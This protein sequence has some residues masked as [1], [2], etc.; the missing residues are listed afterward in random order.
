MALFTAL[1]SAAVSAAV[2]FATGASVFGLATGLSAI[3]MGIGS[4]AMSAVTSLLQPKRPNIT[5]FNVSQGRTL[6]I[7]QPLTYRR[8]LYG[9]SRISGSIG[10]FESTGDNRFFHMII[11]HGE[12]CFEEIGT[13]YF[14][15]EPIFKD[16]LDG[17]GFVTSG[18]FF[19]AD[20]PVRIK[21]HLGCGG[22]P[23]NQTPVAQAAG[24]LIGTMSNNGGLAASFDGDIDQT[25][26]AS[27]EDRFVLI[28]YI[29]KDWG[30]AV[31]KTITGFQAWG[32][33]TTGFSN[34]DGPN[35]PVGITITLQGSTD[36][37]GASIVDLGSAGPIDNEASLLITKMSGITSTTAYRY[38]RLK[39]EHPTSGGTVE[40]VRCT[41][42]IFYIGPAASTDTAD[43]DLVSEMTSWTTDHTLSGIAYTYIRLDANQDMY[44]GGL[45]N[46][47]M[48]CK[49]ALVLDPRDSGTR[50]SPNPAL[51]LYDYLRDTKVGKSVPVAKIDTASVN[52][53]ADICDEFVAV[54]DSTHVVDNTD[55]AND[56]FTL[57][58]AELLLKY[59]TGDHVE[60]TT[61]GALPAPFVDLTDYFV[62]VWQEQTPIKVKLA[63]TYLNALAGTAIDITT[64]GTGIHTL[65]KKAE[66]RYTVNGLVDADRDPSLVITELL[67]AMGGR[68]VKVGSVWK[69]YAAGYV[70][71]TITIDE[72]NLRGPLTIATK[73]SRRVRFNAVKGTYITPLNYG[74]ISNYP[75][76]TNALY[77]TEDNEKRIYTDL[78]LPYTSRPGQ[79][80]RLAK[81]HLERHRQQITVLA[82][83]NLSGFEIE[84]IDIIK[85]NYDRASWTDKEFDVVG[86]SLTPYTAAGGVPA[87]GIDLELRETAE[88]VYDWNS[89]EETIVDPAPDTNMPDAFNVATPTGL[90]LTSGA[91]TLFIKADGTVVSRILASWTAAGDF[92]VNEYEIQIKKS[93]DPD[94]AASWSHFSVREGKLFIYLSAVQDNVDYDV[95]VRSLNAYNVRSDWVTVSDHT[96]V[97]KTAA[98]SSVATLT[99]QQSDEQ[100]TIKY[101]AIADTDLGSYEIRYM[102]AP[103]DWDSA[104]LVTEDTRSTLITS[105]AIPP[106]T[107][108]VGVKAID[109][110]GNYSA[111]AVT[112]TI[113]VVNVNTSIVSQSE[114]A[115]WPG[116]L[117]GYIRH[118]VSGGLIP[119]SNTAASAMTDAQLWDQLVFDPV[120]TSIYE[121]KEINL[122]FDADDMRVFA[123]LGGQIG[124]LES[125]IVDP[126]FSIDYRDE[127]DG[128]DGF[129][130]WPTPAAANFRRLKARVTFTN[131]TGVASFTTYTINVDAQEH[132]ETHPDE[133]IAAA[134]GS[135][136]SFDQQYHTAPAIAVSAEAAAALFAT[137]DNVTTTSVDIFIWDSGGNDVGG[138]AT[139]TVT[140]V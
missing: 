21:K 73:H 104:I 101:P 103:F 138:T 119:E 55:T 87:F 137:Y 32:T 118:D 129:E 115:R 108:V 6:Q 33:N 54:V 44:P 48:N 85:V 1:I 17:S 7:R 25:H 10:V 110:S 89:G 59:Q 62:I 107:W 114:H 3:V 94:V 75:A 51:C 71:P 136:I 106:G 15:D 12:G 16:Q 60:I 42:I 35:Q 11:L 45:P 64:E 76:I 38:H 82:Q 34:P 121:A 43:A 56:L 95:R 31:T 26:N 128:Y 57:N 8:K 92:M 139:I 83:L 93:A 41:E 125:G 130:D 78:D 40:K 63:T 98:P 69:M 86:W 81:I 52:T 36:N 24:G 99:V 53:A 30:A 100:V 5:P 27:S 112:A 117:T 72:D 46:V 66:P 61:T 124:V 135:T 14:N 134:G 122:G 19:D 80:E 47:S 68:L 29:G 4:L 133:T 37:F 120:T 2:S 116:A 123:E 65:T 49:G 97:A 74:E 140:G 67:E 28:G 105:R 79:A 113:T 102:P 111:T 127:A 96:V 126:I 50:W 9:E 132:T 70:A 13:T 77:K 91:S 39:I 58:G 88:E 20:T 90:T 23:A 18:R 131:A 109:T 84:A 22:V